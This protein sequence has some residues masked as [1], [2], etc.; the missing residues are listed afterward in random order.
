MPL[1]VVKSKPSIKAARFALLQPSRAAP[2][3]AALE[4]LL[5]FFR[6]CSPEHEYFKIESSSY[7]KSFYCSMLPRVYALKFTRNQRS[8]EAFCASAAFGI[9]INL[10]LKHCFS[11]ADLYKSSPSTCQTEPGACTRCDFSW[12]RT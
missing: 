7:W 12:I 4:S 11:T 3:A 1:K 5:H 8:T 9:R 6:I 2:S 10:R